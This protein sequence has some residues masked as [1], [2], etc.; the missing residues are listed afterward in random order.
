[1][2][3]YGSKVEVYNGNAK[4][5]KGGLTKQD[6]VVVKDKYGNKRYKSEKQLSSGKKKNTPRDHWAKAVK[7]AYTQL[8]K[9]KVIPNGKFIPVGGET[10][11]GK[12]LYK[13]TSNIFNV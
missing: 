10:K 5:T 13:R 4:F 3:Y 8:V 7:K 9:E 1:M 2:K 11:L 6:I 12:Q